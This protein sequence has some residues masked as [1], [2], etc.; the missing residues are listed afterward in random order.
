MHDRGTSRITAASRSLTF[1]LSNST[2]FHS[3]S[4]SAEATPTPQLHLF[5]LESRDSNDSSRDGNRKQL[6]RK[7]FLLK[8]HDFWYVS[9]VHLLFWIISTV[10]WH[11]ETLA[12]FL[13]DQLYLRWSGNKCLIMEWFKA[14]FPLRV[15]GCGS[16][17]SSCIQRDISN[18]GKSNQTERK[19][20]ISRSEVDEE[21]DWSPATL[22]CGPEKRAWPSPS[23]T[24]WPCPWSCKGQRTA[25]RPG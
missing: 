22:G 3:E 18:W 24:Q 12:A 9:Y 21:D 1:Y 6:M 20:C 13:V 8:P 11:E 17:H 14:Y 15:Y 16:H 23:H 5:T 7:Q 19:V 25:S 10:K 2:W 4:M